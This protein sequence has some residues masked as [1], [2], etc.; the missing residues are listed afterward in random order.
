MRNPLFVVA[1]VLFIAWGIGVITMPLNQ[2][3]HVLLCL[4]VAVILLQVI[5]NVGRR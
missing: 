3:V 2:M 5:K 1:C 4:A